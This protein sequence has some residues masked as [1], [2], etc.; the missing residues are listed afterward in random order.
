MPGT[1]FVFLLIVQ[2]GVILA[3]S[4]LMGFIFARL[5]QPQVMGEMVAGIMLGPSLFGLIAPHAFAAVFPKDSV[6]RLNVLSQVGVIFFLFLVGLELDP[7][8]LKSR[9]RAAVVISNASIFTPFVLGAML[10]LFLYPRLFNDTLA[11]PVTSVALFMGAAMSITAFPVLARILT[12]RNMQKTNVGALTITCAAAND[13]IAWCMLAAVISVARA[14]GVGPGLLTAGKAVIY[15]AVMF[16]LVRPFL[17]RLQLVY[18]RT[19]RLSQNLLALILL[20]VLASAL[21][22]DWIGIH[23]LF[24]AF[25]MGA[26]MPKGTSLSRALTEKL[27]DYTVVF[28]LPIFFAF[29]GL[30]TEI[31]VLNE[32]ML[33]WYTGLIILVACVGKFGGS[34]V[35]ARLCGMGWREASAIGI[36]MN[37]RG[38]M[39]LV[40]LNVGKDLGVITPAI[41]AMMVI[42]AMVTTALTTSVLHWV[43]PQVETEAKK[44]AAALAGKR[45]AVL[46]PVSLPA[47]GASLA[48]IA[49][50]LSP[51]AD[52]VRQIIALNLR[53]SDDGDTL[54]GGSSYRQMAVQEAL[55]PLNDAARQQQ[56]P[57]TEISFVSRDVPSDI[58]RVA[59]QQQANLVL[60]GYH[61]PVWSQSM[62]GGTVHR[63]LA[64]TDCDVAIFVDRRFTEPRTVLVPYLGG[65]HDRLALDF[66][67]RIARNANIKLI[68]LH[69][70]QP[71]RQ[72]KDGVLHA[73][74]V[75][76]RTFNDPTQPT[77]MEF[78]VIEDPSPVDAV[79]REA[80]GVDL[81]VI[82][83]EERWGLE[84]HLFGWRPERIAHQVQSSLLIVRKA[85]RATTDHG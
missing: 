10:A 29:T 58:A 60:M 67:G 4:R 55:S 12:E 76:D 71:N 63:V 44:Q 3:L 39:E 18:Q 20:L 45:M 46:I 25:V 1:R 70:V 2:I 66:A 16:Y 65:K 13:V 73:K 30:R 6:N 77:P 49:A 50:L 74:S 35:A 52:Y 72:A 14:T 85:T 22:T 57:V 68:I 82:G 75:V 5:R 42:M 48:R 47:S 79:V 62:L 40:I 11:M 56:V 15:I 28:L 19:D 78:R 38:L 24:G 43:Y 23:A 80:T 51:A 59:R 27:E 34:A 32:G 21:A 81:V 53:R 9:G 36:L 7:K 83:V 33:W 17:G 37:T 26:I 54:R 8:L 61:K 69:V 84:S 41:F 31:S 64:A